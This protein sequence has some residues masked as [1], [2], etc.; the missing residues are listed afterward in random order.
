[1]TTL[2]L[3][4]GMIP[5]ALGTGPGAEERRAVSI[6]VIGGQSLA[7]FLTLIM[8]PVAYSLVEEFKRAATYERIA[9]P[10]RRL[11]HLVPAFQRANGGVSLNGHSADDA[12][13]EALSKTRRDRE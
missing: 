8:T 11:A 13:R 5:L 6:V 10:F 7:L 3:V 1:M 4:A 12:E 2:T 9:T